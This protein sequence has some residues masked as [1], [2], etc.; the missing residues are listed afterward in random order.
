VLA[1]LERSMK[2]STLDEEP[3]SELGAEAV[4]FRAA[5]E[6]LAAVGKLKRSDLRTLRLTAHHEGRNDPTVGWSYL[7]R[8]A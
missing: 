3:M 2:P 8:T 5:T 7:G 4:D 6:P 1:N